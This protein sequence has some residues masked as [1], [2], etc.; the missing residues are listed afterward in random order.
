[1][2]KRR[3][4]IGLMF[5]GGVLMRTKG[6]RADYRYTQAFLAAEAIDEAVLIDIGRGGPSGASREAMEAFGRRCFAPVAMGG[7]I[8]GLET[9]RL[10]FGMGADKLVLGRSA[11]RNPGLIEALALKYGSN[12]VTVACDVAD[13]R[14]ICA[15]DGAETG[16]SP[17]EWCLEAERRGAGEIFLQSRERDG[18]LGGFPVAELREIA[19]A[20]TIPVVVGTGCGG[21]GHMREAF[22]AGAQGCVTTNIHHFTETAMRGF[23]QRLVEAG[24][25][26]RGVAG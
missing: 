3:V 1:M 17:L 10:F 4:M 5:D 18:S 24:Q 12:A 21:W 25:P 7:W 20:V 11:V 8:D 26:V 23:K 16:F 13:G 15:A 14:A 22:E 2:L 19:A 6:F 9:A